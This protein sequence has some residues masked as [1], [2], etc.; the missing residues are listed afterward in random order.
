MSVPTKL[1]KAKAAL[2]LDHPFFASI[3]L[4]YPLKE[5]PHIKTL[6]I[7]RRGQIHYNPKFVE[8][9]TVPQIVYGLCHEVGHKMGNHAGRIGDRDKEGW[10]KACDA[11]VNDMLNEAKVGE[12]I[13]GGY[14]IPD[15]RNKTLEE[16][17]EIVMAQPPSGGK[18]K[19]K[20]DKGSGD[21]S[22]QGGGNGGIG[23]DLMDGEGE[24]S[25]PTEE[26]TEQMEAQNKIDVAQA[27]AAAKTMGKLPANL[28][29][30]AEDLV[31]VKT[32]WFEILERFMTN[33]VKNEQTWSRP[34]RRFQC[35]GLY[36]PTTSSIGS[37]GEVVI[38]V[39]T[40]GSIGQ[41]E[42]NEFSGHTNRI[43]EQCNPSR[44]HVVYCDSQVAHVDEYTPEQFPIKL[45]PH[46]GGG[47]DMRE[48][49]RYVEEHGLDPECII[50]LTDN[51]TPFPDH[52]AFPTVWAS[53]T[54]VVAPECAGITIHVEADDGNK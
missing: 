2:V 19:G 51:Y 22:G 38:G 23:D 9:L 8:E 15:A 24:G 5:A 12:P 20:G 27:A 35:L 40:S 48:I 29:R 37:M 54:P 47:T 18:G 46:G 52:E 31:H 42:L 49:I 33:K 32:P 43:L 1:E 4:K 7:D 41:K 36:M 44:V 34:N 50:I 6:G 30:F 39:D 17:Y 28:Q 13:P 26:E 25:A 10:N 16:L 45:E 53:T 3:L 21:S 11:W 14:T